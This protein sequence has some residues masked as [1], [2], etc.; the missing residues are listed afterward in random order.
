VG[1]TGLD[2]GLPQLR[3]GLERGGEVIE[4]WHEVAEES[5][6][7]GDVHGGGEDIVGGLRGVHVVVGVYR[8]S[9]ELRGESGEH[10]V[11][12]HVRRGAAAGLVGVD[13]KLVVV[14]AGDQLV[15]GEH[16]G[17]RDRFREDAELQVDDRGGTLD[18]CECHD[19]CRLESAS[20]DGEVLD[21]ALRLGSVEGRYRHADFA[22]RVVLDAVLGFSHGVVR[23]LFR[24]AGGR[25][26]PRRRRR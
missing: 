21:R 7:H 22:H 11:D 10:L 25:W 26:G 23:P 15:R 3:L 17:L 8:G 4:G 1:A 18:S 19:L 12:V 2:H 16:H 24:C 6:S 20:G 13:R 5:A 14:M 9:R